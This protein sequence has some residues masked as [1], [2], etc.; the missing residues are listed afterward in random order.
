MPVSNGPHTRQR[1]FW[2]FLVTLSLI[3]SAAA[4]LLAAGLFRLN[5]ETTDKINAES[6][7]RKQQT[8][9][10]LELQYRDDIHNLRVT[11]EYLLGLT[12]KQAREVINVAIAEQLPQAERRVLLSAPPPYC[13]EPHVGLA[14]PTPK[15]PV[16]PKELRD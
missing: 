1:T 13:S 2:R 4:C 5:S 8:C 11:Y 15:V 3:T 6:V 16:R 14:G 10:Y 7:E 9:T 12:G